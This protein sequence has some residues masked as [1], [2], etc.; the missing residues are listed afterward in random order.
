MCCLRPLKKKGFCF[1]DVSN[2]IDRNFANVLV[3]VSERDVIMHALWC[4]R[5][6][7]VRWHRTEVGELLKLLDSHF[8]VIPVLVE[9]RA[10]W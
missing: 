5:N 9:I 8:V 4:L 3:C 6:V 1:T 2:R 10:H 7:K